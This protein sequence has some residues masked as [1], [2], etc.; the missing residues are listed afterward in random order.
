MQG[1]LQQK[2][3]SKSLKLVENIVPATRGRNYL[4]DY[5]KK[6]EC[7]QSTKEDG[8]FICPASYE[9]SWLGVRAA[10]TALWQYGHP[11]KALLGRADPLWKEARVPAEHTEPL[12]AGET[13]VWRCPLLL[14]RPSLFSR[15]PR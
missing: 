10:E 4:K 11:S 12:P 2:H 8:S 14:L 7:H 1:R 9:S 15:V 13:E 5:H 3:V 6:R